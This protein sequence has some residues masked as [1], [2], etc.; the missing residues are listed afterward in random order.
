MKEF[1]L[2]KF[3]SVL[4]YTFLFTSILIANNKSNDLLNDS[5]YI[6]YKGRGETV[7]EAENDALEQ[8]SKY[9]NMK[10][11]TE[12]S[13][14]TVVS[15]NNKS[16]T[17]LQNNIFVESQT[18]L[19]A[20]HYT[21][22]SYNKKQKNYEV[23]AYIN[24]EEAWNIYE[25]KIRSITEKFDGTISTAK[26]ENE[27]FKQILFYKKAQFLARTNN[28]EKVIQFA[29]GLY[30]EKAQNYEYVLDEISI[31]PK[32]INSKSKNC[33]IY[34]EHSNKQILD[35][36]K[37]LLSDLCIPITE[38]K[39]NANIICRIDF[40][41]NKQVLP[42]GTFYTPSIYVSFT[43]DNTTL[44]NYSK[45]LKKVGA[46]N[47]NVAEQRLYTAIITDLRQSLFAD[48]FAN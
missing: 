28:L 26:S 42:A 2:K 27:D 32:E 6:A 1:S 9:F 5:D 44:F 35:E 24:K 41:D 34:L 13:E 12:S 40:K 36:I 47:T 20:V 46:K 38:I 11:H 7:K 8:I 15:G 18:E 39:E 3:I 19:F 10:I 31:I 23:I 37:N 29:Y 17:E 48:F 30:Y 4:L 43:K 16:Q 21:E 14:T 45:N 22:P 33:T 25:S